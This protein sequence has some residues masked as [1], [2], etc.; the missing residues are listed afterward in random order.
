MCIKKGDC[1]TSYQLMSLTRVVIVKPSK[2]N[3]DFDTCQCAVLFVFPHVCVLIVLWVE[4]FTYACT[5]VCVGSGY[6]CIYVSL[7]AENKDHVC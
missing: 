3:V 1:G 5:C 7:S 6:L 2:V 4:V